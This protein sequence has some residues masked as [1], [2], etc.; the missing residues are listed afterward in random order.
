MEVT[1]GEFVPNDEVDELRWLAATDADR[2]LTYADDRALLGELL[3][4]FEP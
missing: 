2:L 1:A 4:A 3:G